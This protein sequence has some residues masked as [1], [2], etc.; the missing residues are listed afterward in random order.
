MAATRGT[1]LEPSRKPPVHE[2]LPPT[3]QT[4]PVVTK[5]PPVGQPEIV[6]RERRNRW[7]AWAVAGVLGLLVVVG[8]LFVYT[9]RST[10]PSVNTLTGISQEAW[11]Q[12]RA[13][14][15]AGIQNLVVNPSDW[16]VFRAGER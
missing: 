2:S 13:G 1:L 12:Y 11:A 6:E 14:E 5:R 7:W 9:N 10:T 3:V 4:K 8:G 16:Q 15:R